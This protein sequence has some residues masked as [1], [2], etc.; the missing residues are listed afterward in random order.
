[1]SQQKLDF[2]TRRRMQVIRERLEAKIA[3]AKVF[4][5]PRIVRAVEAAF[6]IRSPLERGI[7]SHLLRLVEHGRSAK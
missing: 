4:R 1:M 5:K 3:D 2:R 6:G 7:D